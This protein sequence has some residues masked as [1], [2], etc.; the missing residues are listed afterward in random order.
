MTKAK[1]WFLRI[2]AVILC[3]INVLSGT[4][5]YSIISAAIE[6]SVP[7][8]DE[9][10]AEAL[11][12]AHFIIEN[13]DDLTVAQNSN[14]QTNETSVSSNNNIYYNGDES[15]IMTA[16]VDLPGDDKLYLTQRWL[17]KTYKN[18]AG[19]ETIDEDG[20]N[21]GDTVKALIQA[22][23][24]ELG[25]NPVTKNFGPATS[26]AYQKNILYP[27]EGVTDNK[28]VIL[29]GALWCKGYS[30]GYDNLTYD[31]RNDDV[32]VKAVFDEAMEKSI[33]QL[34]TDAGLENPDSVVTLNVMKALLSMD[35]FVLLKGTSFEPK[36]E[37]RTAQQKF[38]RK[39]E[40]YIGIMPCD[41]IFS[42]NTQRAIIKILQALEG[43]TAELTTTFGEQTKAHCP[44]IPYKRNSTAA[45]NYNGE[46]YS[47]ADIA[48][49][50]ELI[51]FTLFVNGFGDGIC[52]GVFDSQTQNAIRQFQRS[53]AIPETGIAD[54]NTWMSLFVSYGN[55]SRSALACD[56]ATK[57]TAEKAKTLYDNGYRYVG[58]YL[59]KVPGGLDKDITREEAQIIFDAGLRFF[60]IYQTSGDDLTYFT[61]EQGTLDAYAAIEAASKL[62]VPRDTII[63][64]AADVDAMDS[65]VTNIIIPYFAKIHEVM[66]D[67]I[68]KAG[69][70]SARNTCTRVSNEGYAC[71]S[72][73]SD[74]SSGYSGNLGFTMPTN[75]A[76]DQF[77]TVS[78]GTGSGKISIDKDGFSGRDL[79]V[80][81]LDD[82]EYNEYKEFNV[83]G[84][85][86]DSDTIHGPI[87]N[88]LGKEIELF[89]F[90]VN[91]ELPLDKLV[92]ESEYDTRQQELNVIIGLDVYEYSQQRYGVR[93]KPTGEKYNQAF[94]E[95]KEMIST[96]KN[97]YS[98]IENPEFKRRFRDIK[99]CLYDRGFNM[100]IYTNGYVVGYMTISFK[101]EKPVL[102]TSEI[103]FI[104]KA[105]AEVYYPTGI[106]TLTIRLGIEGSIEGGLGLVLQNDK[107][108]LGGHMSVALEPSIGACIN[109]YAAKATAGVGG[110]V[111]FNFRFPFESFPKSFT[112]IFNLSIF[113]EYTVLNRHDEQRVT[114][115]NKQLYPKLTEEQIVVMSKDGFILIEPSQVELLSDDLPNTFKNNVQTYANP[116][117]VN[118]GNNKMFMVY[119]DSAPDRIAENGTMLMYSIYDGTL[120]S[121]PLP[122]A[123]DG[124]ADF[125]PKICTDANGGVH[126][127]WQNASTIF[128]E[129]ATLDDTATSIDLSYIY[130]DGTNFSNA[131][132]ITK[133]NQ[134]Y[135]MSHKIVS[136]GDN[137]SVV[138]QQNSENDVFGLSGTNS[139]YR[140]QLVESS[141]NN[142]ET[143]ATNL[144]VVTNIDTSYVN[145]ENVVAYTAKSSTDTTVV[146]DIEVYYIAGNQTTQLTND[147]LYDYSAKFYNNELYWYT[148]NS[149]VRIVNGDISTKTVVLDNISTDIADFE[150]IGNENGNKSIVWEYEDD[151]GMVFF[152]ADYNSE[153]NTFSGFL[154]IERANGVVRGWDACMMS[155]GQIELAYCYADYL[156]EPDENGLPYGT[157]SLIQRPVEEICDI[158]VDP[159]TVADS[160]VL[161]G[162][163]INLI[164]DVYNNGSKAVNAFEVTISDNNGNL[165]ETTAV[166]Q[167][168][169]PGENAEI[170]I[171]FTAPSEITKSDYNITIL[172]IGQT[173]VNLEDNNTVFSMGFSDLVIQDI[174]ETRTQT[175]R[176]LTVSVSN[177]GFDSID[178]ATVN[179]YSEGINGELLETQ[180]VYALESGTNT[181]VVFEI[182]ES[183]LDSSVS[184][185]ARL[186]YIYAET[187]SYESNYGNN[188]N[189]IAL[190]PDYTVT[191][192]AESGGTVSG[193]GTY[194][195]DSKATIK[196]TP[197]PGYLFEGWYENDELLVGVPEEIE[198]S[199][200]SNRTLEARFIPSDLMIYAVSVDGTRRTGNTLKF[201]VQTD[202]E[203]QPYLW[204]FYVY[205]NDT[206]RYSVE[207][208]VTNSFTYRPQ[209][210]GN[211]KVV[212]S[213]SNETGY[214]TTYEQELKIKNYS[215]R[216]DATISFADSIPKNANIVKWESSNEDVVTV[217]SNGIITGHKLGETTVRA[218]LEDGGSY[219]W[220]VE[221]E[222]NWWQTILVTF[223]I[224]LFFLPFWVAK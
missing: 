141:W 121:S 116:Q 17:N 217:D 99:G 130:W 215:V 169:Q 78:I 19:Y 216:R 22:L 117:I 81:K 223:G 2:V 29:Q 49:F 44:E 3:V 20:E 13:V 187:D 62:G 168:L 65:N 51:Q 198:L 74:L 219:S 148:D 143:L 149:I 56:C 214:E 195:N 59:T 185:E 160:D 91:F 170:N 106:P 68:Y 111:S 92:F 107:Y 108:S 151:T 47:N 164:A 4:S 34:K 39:Y 85:N 50:T 150:I 135:E 171:P 174:T 152:S 66:K 12:N 87:V 7:I 26:A 184:E 38:N 73:V 155:D 115:Y 110:K 136:S 109:L 122:I 137:V 104:G 186:Y 200:N 125:E 114:L 53:Q 129:G 183:S 172:P 23:Q 105:R 6:E 161:P 61:E 84:G 154:P 71:S 112:A 69:I 178:S 202:G 208:S 25:I 132:T 205:E 124:T 94:V 207:D 224:G 60:P 199:V 197:E 63:Y 75:W 77:A 5:S 188:D 18:V 76:F 83:D 123:D 190:H 120:W 88:F 11:S 16:S 52:D 67:S 55:K 177:E 157:L 14:P 204:S 167:L 41:G 173:D 15:D 175:G 221:T 80:G 181:E 70:Y 134:D 93:E 100:G 33:I 45:K 138:W 82:V 58:R 30:G 54:I 176:K 222:L 131:A 206:I 98:G 209:H 46:Y 118:L 165:I 192:N 10:I 101:G 133:N 97:P 21:R 189:S 145:S 27:Q 9:E 119:I 158:Y 90:D 203:T 95:V 212:V 37:I 142:T 48:N 28:F 191:L 218:Y 35:A 113:L 127:L 128:E 179:L 194:I 156:T 40:R 43:R 102:K 210:A 31:E 139:I 32:I 166:E 201:Y 24:H 103:A 147:S 182:E 211:Y 153:T 96:I 42:A 1:K 180:T 213:V 196:A 163:E 193:S 36:P 220:V 144:S 57:L 72:F 86:T 146:N 159:I 8:S 79:G 140:R 162:E 64:F 126:I 89:A